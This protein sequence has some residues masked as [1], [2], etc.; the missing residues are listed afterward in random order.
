MDEVVLRFAVIVLALAFPAWA[1]LS[2]LVVLGRW[3]YDRGS[4]PGS[5]EL[6]A[7]E[8]E[9][10][11]RRVTR[12]PRTEWGRWRRVAALARLEQAHHPA[13]PSLV[14]IVL[15]DKDPRVA[16]AA[17]RTLGDIG[18]EW[19]IDLLVSTLRKGP[20]PRSRVAAELE[21]L[22]PAPGPKLVPLLRDW[23]PTVRFWGAAL[24]EPYPNLGESSLIALTWDPDPNV[25]AAAVETLGS[26]GGA[27]VGAA[28][29]ACLDDPEW[30]VRVHAA[31]AA[32][33]VLGA[34]AA[35]T[36]I[37][38]LADERWW[39]RT[40]AKDALRGMGTE[41][42]PS[43]LS[44]LTHDDLFARNGAAEV[45]QDIGFVDFLALDDPRSPVL[46]QIYAAGGERLRVA[47]EQR[48]AAAEAQEAQVA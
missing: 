44:V 34:S 46:E 45:L 9:R 16:T 32:G 5:R 29:L 28:T 35:P 27:A 15:A 10:L 1:L 30:F 26:R 42:V 33:R 39:V 21:R 38:L 11:V 47:T 31:R 12:S 18:D 48:I 37:R 19:A 14:R 25:R 8:A 40:A 7:R 43:L 23:N 20:G 22:A 13:V 6:S 3:N 24:L 4:E 17:V 2:A 41:A 36:L